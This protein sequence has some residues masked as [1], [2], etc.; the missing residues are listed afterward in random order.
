MKIGRI[1]GHCKGWIAVD[2]WIPQG[3]VTKSTRHKNGLPNW[4]K[5]EI[6]ERLTI[7]DTQAFPLSTTLLHT[8]P[9]EIYRVEDL[10]EWIEDC[11]WTG[12]V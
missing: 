1:A 11:H 8:D 6:A 7:K 12:L 3:A 4:K 9:E 2:V 10:A 5:P